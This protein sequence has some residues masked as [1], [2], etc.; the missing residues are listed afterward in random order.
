MLEVCRATGVEPLV[1]IQPVKGAVYDQTAYTRDVRARYYDMV[2]SACARAGV[3]TADFSDCEYDPLFL[4][5]Y[6]HPSDYGAA[7]DSQ[8]L[9]GFWRG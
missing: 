2:R 4:R 8:A 6:S 7:L 9:Y 3:R 1:V 5:D